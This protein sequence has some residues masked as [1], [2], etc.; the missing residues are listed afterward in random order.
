MDGGYI[1]VAVRRLRGVRKGW[2][3]VIL[4]SVVTGFGLWFTE[5]YGGGQD[6]SAQVG[7]R[8]EEGE[9]SVKSGKH[10]PVNRAEAA[11]DIANLN[12]PFIL[13]EGQSDERVKFYADTFSGTVFVTKSGEI[14][15][16]I[17]KVEDY[18]PVNGLVLKEEIVGGKVDEVKGEGEVGAKVS[19]FK[20]NIS[21]DWK[22]NIPTYDIVGLGKAYGDNVEKLFYIKPGAEFDDIKVKLSGG[23][24]SV[25]KHGELEVETEL[26]TVKFTKPIAYQENEGNREFIEAAYVVNGDEYGFKVGEYDTERGLVIDPLLASTFLG[27]SGFFE[28]GFGIALDSRGNVYVAGRTYASNFPGVDSESADRVFSGQEVFIAKLDSGLSTIMAATYLGGSD[29]DNEQ[30]FGIAIDSTDNVYVTGTTSASNF[31]G[32]GAGSADSSF[33]GGSEGFVVKLNSGLSRILGATYLGG[34]GSDSGNAINIDGAGNIYVAGNTSSSDFPGIRAGS[35][36]RVFDELGEGFLVKLNSSLSTIIS[37]TYLGGDDFDSVSAIA[38]DSVTGNV[39]AGG[40]TYSTDFP[41]VVGG[42]PIEY[43]MGMKGLWQC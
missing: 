4:C 32:I 18:K 21:S 28:G 39:Y 17:P 3:F 23:E 5:T 27:G 35:A 34:S 22:S 37:G 9:I 41:G 16:S 38:L 40:E 24:L 20:G 2:F 26:G 31:P 12:M 10:E 1:S 19:Y 14:I 42:L 13:N 7:E 36:D 29:N 6:I 15:Y 33:A 30:C 43:P 11:R 8:N 25:N